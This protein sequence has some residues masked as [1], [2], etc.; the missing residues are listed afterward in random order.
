M[1]EQKPIERTDRTDVH[2]PFDPEEAFDKLAQSVLAW[3]QKRPANAVAL[4]NACSSFAL[5]IATVVISISTSKQV[6][7]LISTISKLA[8][9]ATLIEA[10]L[11]VAAYPLNVQG[12]GNLATESAQVPPPPIPSKHTKPSTTAPSPVSRP[13]GKS[14]NNAEAQQSAKDDR[15]KIVFSESG[16][17]QLNLTNGILL[18]MDLLNTGSWQ[19]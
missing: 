14:E 11:S 3:L 7:K 15:P 9:A 4:L 10:D 6:D 2:R 16:F 1:N 19:R 13:T 8:G 5:V 18:K 17:V 12:S